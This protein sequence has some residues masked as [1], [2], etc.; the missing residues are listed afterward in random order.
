MARDYDDWTA[1]DEAAW[2]RNEEL[3]HEYAE[4]LYEERRDRN[5]HRCQCSGMDMPG[6]CP[7]PANCPLADHDEP[8]EGEDV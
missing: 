3:R 7:G 4:E 5:A 1:R 8:D 2:E 6:S